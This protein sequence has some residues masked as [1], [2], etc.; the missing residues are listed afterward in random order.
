MD[1]VPDRCHQQQSIPGR[2]SCGAGARNTVRKA[3]RPRLRVVRA[4]VRKEGPP[5]P[6]S[7]SLLCV[8]DMSMGISLL[9]HPRRWAPPLAPTMP[10][11]YSLIHFG[12]IYYIPNPGDRAANKICPAYSQSGKGRGEKSKQTTTLLRNEITDVPI[13]GGVADT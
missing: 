13:N 11:T 3:A 5:A 10:P 6:S 8:T 12:S 2:Q 7:C 1:K 9:A 4:L